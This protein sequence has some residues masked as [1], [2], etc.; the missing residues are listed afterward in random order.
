MTQPELAI[1]M[2]AYNEEGCIEAVAQ[3]W[4]AA[5]AELGVQNGNLVVVNDGSKDS[6]GKILDA[7]AAKNKNLIVVHQVNGGHGKALMTAYNKGLELNPEW[8]FHVDSD[9][10]FD[11]KD[12]KVLWSKRQ[13]SNFITGYRKVRHDALHRLVITKI[14]VTLN[15]LFFRK[16]LKDANIP[17]RLIKADYLRKLLA[18]LPSEVFAPN[19]FLV[20]LAARDGQDLME[21]PISHSDR[22]T[23]KVSIVKWRLIKACLRSARELFSFSL[24]VSSKIRTLRN[25]SGPA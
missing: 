22:A 8:I 23:G 13:Q 2:P 24:S 12:L 7:V 15:F 6:T 17:F 14:L 18:L 11:P 25:E 5:F 10:Q 4:L 21:I 20:A 16:F 1:V 3:K 19:I 9:D